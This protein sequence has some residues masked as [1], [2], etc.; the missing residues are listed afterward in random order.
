MRPLRVSALLVAGALALAACTTSSAPATAETLAPED[1]PLLAYARSASPA[2]LAAKSRVQEQLVVDC[3]VEA[4]F[5]FRGTDEQSGSDDVAF[6]PRSREFAETYGY[7]V[8]NNPLGPG[9]VLESLLAPAGEDP[10]REY[11]DSLDPAA[12]Q[13]FDE[14]LNGVPDGSGWQGAGCFGNAYQAV[15]GSNPWE[16]EQFRSLVNGMKSIYGET[17]RDERTI[18]LNEEWVA[19]LTEAGFAGIANRS[20]AQAGF[21]QELAQLQQEFATAHPPVRGQEVPEF[22]TDSPEAQEAQARE[23]A[24]AVADWDCRE[25]LNFDSEMLRTQFEHEE[26]FIAE[27]TTELEAFRDAL[28]QWRDAE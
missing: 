15:F 11:Y 10:N 17:Q 27:H 9:G 4:G 21:M 20:T 18:A 7:G 2:E 24:Q 23:I 14:A 26:Q 8:F 12:Q 13:A 5:D 3:M 16:D 1:S 19:C 25:K 6:D 28:A 22:S